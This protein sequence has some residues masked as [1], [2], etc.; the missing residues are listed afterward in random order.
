[1]FYLHKIKFTI[2]DIF[3]GG[4]MLFVTSGIEMHYYYKSIYES[5]SD[6]LVEN[7]GFPSGRHI[8]LGILCN[9]L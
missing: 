5:S 7:N 8:Q 9:M 3:D 4:Y 2:S 1:M 6:L